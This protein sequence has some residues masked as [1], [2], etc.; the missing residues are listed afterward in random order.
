MARD[1]HQNGANKLP[2]EPNLGPLTF[3]LPEL[4]VT[5]DG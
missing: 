1:V 2:Y 5:A 4:T 3:D